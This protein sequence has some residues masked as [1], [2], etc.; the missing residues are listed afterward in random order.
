MHCVFK[1]FSKLP[2]FAQLSIPKIYLSELRA[3]HQPF[4][5]PSVP[6][7]SR[8]RNETL[9]ANSTEPTLTS[10]S[11]QTIQWVHLIILLNHVGDSKLFSDNFTS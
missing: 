2:N 11:I 4:P 3:R 6:I 1:K 9:L 8:Q 7:W 5:C 10:D